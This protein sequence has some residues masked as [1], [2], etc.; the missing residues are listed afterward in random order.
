MQC[1]Q[2]QLGQDCFQ[3]Y[4]FQPLMQPERKGIDIKK[5]KYKIKNEN[6][7]FYFNTCL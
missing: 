7:I 1:S 5:N 6:K 2:G 3:E 4:S